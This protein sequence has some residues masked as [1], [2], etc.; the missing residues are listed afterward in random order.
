MD[1]NIIIMEPAKTILITA[2]SYTM[3]VLGILVILIIGWAIAKAIQNIVTRF[4]KIAQLDVAA[5]KAGVTKI[6]VKG[7]IKYT[8]AELIGML[9]YWLGML[10]VVV[11]G[12]NALHLTVAALLL[13]QIVT[14]IPHVIAA[15]FILSIGMF[16]AVLVSK[17]INTVAVNAGL[18]QPQLLAK[19]SETIIVVL[20]IIM[21]L[22]QLQISTTILNL[23][24]SIILGSIG[25]ALALAFGL[26]GKDAAAKIIKENLDNLK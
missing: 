16:V 14:Y 26:G 13:N 20:A 25:V 15:V 2:V 17:T 23:V 3:R 12:V 4:L 18:R 21:A 22:E 19:I 24:M 1:W 6:L 5:D 9:V 10:I 11:A 7:E 8:L